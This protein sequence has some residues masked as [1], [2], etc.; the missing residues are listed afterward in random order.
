MA[1]GM[2]RGERDASERRVILTGT[3]SLPF[4]SVPKVGDAH[5]VLYVKMLQDCVQQELM[6]CGEVVCDNVRIAHDVVK[7]NLQRLTGCETRG[8]R[9]V[10]H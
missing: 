3:A 1:K 2:V 4:E 6:F 8:E 10:R 9:V 7:P 5:V